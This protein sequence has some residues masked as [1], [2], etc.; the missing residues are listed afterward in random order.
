MENQ[1]QIV[2]VITR[3]L[4]ETAYV[5]TDTLSRDTMPNP[6]EW[7]ASG[8][9]L[10]FFGQVSGEMRMWASN[11]F[12]RCVAANMLGIGEDDPVAEEKGLDALKETLNIIVGNYLTTV[13][14]E[15]PIFD[16]GLPK[17]LESD[18]LVIDSENTD[19][20]LLIA[21]DYP[22][23]FLVENRSGTDDKSTGC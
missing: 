16:L 14:G 13:Y 6:E 20:I 4:E 18:R 3:I 1:E 11:G 15:Q 21:D 7:N 17:P 8:V 19:G 2:E 9:V 10:Q 23:L 5:F 22:I 12:L